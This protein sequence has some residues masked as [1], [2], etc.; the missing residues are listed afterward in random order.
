MTSDDRSIKGF[1]NNLGFGPTDHP[2]SR[3]LPFRV[4]ALGDFG[5]QAGPI[6]VDAHDLDA[7]MAKIQ[8]HVFFEVPNHLGSGRL[9]VDVKLTSI[10]ALEPD[11][12][13]RA[14]PA[15]ATV[16]DFIERATAVQDGSTKPA[17]FKSDLSA[18]AAVP[19]LKRPLEAVLD[20]L[21]GSPPPAPARESTE[22][23][24]GDSALDGIFS[25]V[26]TGGPAESAGSG[27]GAF[28][29]SLGKSGGSGGPDLAEPIRAARKLLDTQLAEVINHERFRQLEARWRGLRTFLRNA[30][31]VQVALLSD[32]APVDAFHERVFPGE[33]QGN[34]D[35]PLA[36]ILLDAEITN[37]PAAL[38]ELQQLGDSAGQI[39]APVVF[40]VDEPFLGT[41]L[42]SLAAL[43]A[44]GRLFEDSRFDKWRSLREKEP[45]RWLSA[46]MNGFVV[47]KPVAGG[48]WL[49][50]S[51]VWLVGASVARAFARS[52]WPASHTGA[53]DGE[54]GS[55]PTREVNGAEH[56]LQALLSDRHLKDLSRAGFTPMIGQPNNDSAWV[57]MAPTVRLPSRAE[58][59][60]KLGTLGYQLLAARAGEM[61][62]RA[63]AQIVVPGDVHASAERMW[64]FAAGMLEGTGGGAGAEVHLEGETLV[65]RMRFGRDVLGGVELVV[66]L[67]L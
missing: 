4:L 10:K 43:D 65:M 26:D 34:S 14:I 30:K 28:A 47:R 8:P 39:Q 45:A 36:L 56:P 33:L 44:P 18:F 7:I 59:E 17:A 1:D 61:L 49:Y 11:A 25:M 23:S 21:G 20:K 31:G 41:D 19:A 32:P 46:T 6:P 66:G 15:T 60:G 35:A 48:D 22:S 63:K 5:A 50:G 64:Q 53:A 57:I 58:E 40:A 24:D 2:E 51:A 54:I 42:P 29:A 52:G 12:V 38:D 55:F 9:E 62:I 3:P 67:G 27:I 13:A 37:S 16:Q